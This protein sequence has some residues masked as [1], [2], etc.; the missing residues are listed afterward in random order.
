VACH[1]VDDAGVSGSFIDM[2]RY[3]KDNGF[4]DYAIVDGSVCLEGSGPHKAP[5]N[6]GRTI[7]MKDRNA[8]KKYFA[9]ASDDA[10]AVDTTLAALIGFQVDDIKALRMARHLNLGAT[11]RIELA[12]ATLA[13]LQVPDW[14]KPEI[15]PESYFS[16]CK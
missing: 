13:D 10:V 12:G 6:D 9:L 8:A 5:V 2:L 7:H 14:M 1:G 16:F 3:R 4:K 11:D 15:L